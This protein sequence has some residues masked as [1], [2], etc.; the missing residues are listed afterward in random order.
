[1][2]LSVNVKPG[3]RR[4]GV[5]ISGDEIVLRV[6]ERAIDGAANDGCIRTLA[7]HLDLAPSSI[8]LVRG[9][10]SRRKTFAIDGLD[11]EAV[12]ERLR[13]AAR[14]SNE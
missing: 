2:L 12:W 11:A 9:N 4:P 13:L 6:R 1:M 3:S 14:C 5:A 7:S 10:Q 8:E